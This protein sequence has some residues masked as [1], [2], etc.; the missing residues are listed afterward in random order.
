MRAGVQPGH[1]P[2]HGLHGQR[3]LAEVMAV[4]VG[5][6]ELAA[7]RGLER[8]GNIEDAVVVKV[9]PRD[10]VV[11][12]R[13]RGLFFDANGALLTIKLDHTVALR[14]RN[15]IRKDRGAAGACVRALQLHGQVMAVED[16]VAKDK[17][18]CIL[19]HKA[20]AQNES[21]RQAVGRGLHLVG[22][23]DAPLAAIAQQLGKARGIGRRGNQ[24]D[25]AHARQHEGG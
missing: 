25:V 23:I 6:L 19:A 20:A 4:H 11:G 1:A 10:G 18:A 7:R 21:L 22:N 16:V 8:G 3:A 24:Q 15:T 13:P 5:D 17:D 12:P 9:Q 14:I 2:A